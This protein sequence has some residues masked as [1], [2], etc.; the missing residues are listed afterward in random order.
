MV[1]QCVSLW[2]PHQIQ[3]AIQVQRKSFHTFSTAKFLSVTFFEDALVSAV[4][5]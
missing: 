4:E 5:I 1:A 2:E 3:S